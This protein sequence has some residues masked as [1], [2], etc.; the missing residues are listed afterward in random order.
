MEHF[1]AAW[2][3]WPISTLRS[4][5]GEAATG[6]A[7]TSV[8][9]CH[10]Q[11]RSRRERASDVP[12]KQLDPEEHQNNRMRRVWSI[13]IPENER[14]WLHDAVDD[15]RVERE[16]VE[17]QQAPCRARRDT[18]PCG[19]SVRQPVPDIEVQLLQLVEHVGEL[20]GRGSAAP[21]DDGVEVAALRVAVVLGHA[22]SVFRPILGGDA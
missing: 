9:A 14:T 7:S 19:Q 18:R 2:A 11:H 20:I 15:A 13:N 10:G 21:G 22:R 16:V 17:A 3:S 4:S 6:I 8:H 5:C 1:C 12:P